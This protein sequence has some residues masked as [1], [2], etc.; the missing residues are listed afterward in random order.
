[1]G[2]TTL[3]VYNSNFNIAEHNRNFELYTDTFDEFSIAKIKDE[4]EE[5]LG[6]SDVTLYHLQHEIRGPRV[7]QIYKKLG[8]GK[9]SADDYNIL[10]MGSA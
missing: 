9:S 4:F 8:L 2:L 3:K 7:L 5:F 10:L 1:M 6:I